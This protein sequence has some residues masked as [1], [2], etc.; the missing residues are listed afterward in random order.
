MRR[1]DRRRFVAIGTFG[2]ALALVGAGPGLKPKDDLLNKL[3]GEETVG[4]VVDIRSTG[5]FKVEGV[6]LV[7]GLDGTGSNPG[8]SAYRAK[9]LDEMQKAG[10]RDAEAWFAS[11]TT[12][13]VLVKARIPTGISTKDVFDAEVELPADSTTKSLAGGRLLTTKLTVVHMSKEGQIDGQMMATAYG[14]VITAGDKPDDLRRGRVFGGARAKYDIPYLMILKDNHKSAR[15]AALLQS[16]IS[17]RF[18]QQVGHDQKGMALAKTDQSL[19]LRV[20]RNYH[21]NQLRYFQVINRLPM[22]DTPALRTERL[23]RWS[24]QLLDP[25]TAGEAA[26]RLEG[27][28]PNAADALRPGL[29]SANAQVRFFAAEALA[30]LGD[31]SGVDMLARGAIDQP[32]FRAQALAALAALDQPAS[33]QKLRDL[34]GHPDPQV[35]YGAFN[36]LRTADGTDPYLG[37]VP[38]VRDEPA[39]PAGDEA[40][41]MA[42]TPPRRK[43]PKPE[44]PFTLY[45]V[46]CEGPPLIHVSNS[47]RCEVV[48]FGKGQKLLTP[49]VL[50]GAGSLLLNAADGD[51]R[52]QVSRITTNLAADPERKIDSKLDLGE[53]IR[54]MAAL[55]ASYAEIVALLQA[56]DRQRNLPGPMVVDAVPVA[57]PAYDAAQLAGVE[58]KKD[59]AVGRTKL[60]AK[61]KAPRR[62]LIDRFLRRGSPSPKP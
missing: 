29:A 43:P 25:K 51:E 46:D 62:G 21:Q 7:V 40:M 24:K 11:R 53:L 9:L 34:M 15:T 60:D 23:A 2:A 52:V 36:A 49:V 50:G 16:I 41:A 22:I 13:L 48:V 61:D 45:I 10:V 1:I 28:G 19:V 27:V 38:V 32:E 39:D 31:S 3:K 35:R 58:P 5:E 55:D 59:D 42:I 26:L 20:P 37:R 30:Y 18:H 6:G 4:D 12:S 33:A 47:R 54:S 17:T 8:P 14:P 56:A 44:D 57:K